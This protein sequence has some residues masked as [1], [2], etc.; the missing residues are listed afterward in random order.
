VASHCTRRARALDP[1]GAGV[2]GGFTRGTEAIVAVAQDRVDKD[3]RN[4]RH[5]QGVKHG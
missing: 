5:V 2:L 4:A 3:D 1:E